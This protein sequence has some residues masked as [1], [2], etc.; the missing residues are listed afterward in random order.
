M[1]NWK[2]WN[3]DGVKLRRDTDVGS[4]VGGAHMDARFGFRIVHQSSTGLDVYRH[5]QS[6]SRAET[7]LKVIVGLKGG[8]T[9]HVQQRIGNTNRWEI[10]R[11][12]RAMPEN[13]M[14]AIERTGDT[15]KVWDTQGP[16]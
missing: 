15:K 5:Y 9:Y 6:R 2:D 14:K 13:T 12:L 7:D 11:T 1:V 16:F 4:I 8:V 10:V 3:K